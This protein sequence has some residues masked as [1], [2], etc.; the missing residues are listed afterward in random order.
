MNF[1]K[2]V[3]RDMAENIQGE[4]PCIVD[5]AVNLKDIYI[6]EIKFAKKLQKLGINPTCEKGGDICTIGFSEKDKK[7]YGWSHR[8]MY[9]FRIGE[10]V[11]KGD[12]CNSSGYDDE[13]LK[14]HPEKDKSLPIGFTAKTLDDCKKMAIAF[15]ESVS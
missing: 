11:K 13:Y 9:G 10:I 8:A 5:V 15:A 2:I 3:K 4:K 1:Y 12:C 7:W 6:G 14:E